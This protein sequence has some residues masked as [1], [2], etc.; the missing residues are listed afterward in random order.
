MKDL[1][2]RL[3]RVRDISGKTELELLVSTNQTL[4]NGL[5]Y[6]S[7]PLSALF[8]DF[9]FE[10]LQSE[11][12]KELKNRLIVNEKGV[13]QYAVRDFDYNYGYKINEEISNN[14]IVTE[15]NYGQRFERISEISCKR[16]AIKFAIITLL[17]SGIYNLCAFI[18]FDKNFINVSFFIDREN[19]IIEKNM[20]K[21]KLNA[22]L[23]I[24][25]A[26]SSDKEWLFMK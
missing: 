26:E 11:Y 23:I 9:N 12:E 17:K 3:I 20:D 8:V 24:K 19:E 6:K 21:Y 14:E 7:I 10:K 25:L 16:E 1:K 2:K 18:N 22:I 4:M 13:C 5:N 15:V